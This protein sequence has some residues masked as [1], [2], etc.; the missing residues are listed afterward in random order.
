MSHIHSHLLTAL[1]MTRVLTGSRSACTVNCLVPMTALVA[2]FVLFAL[3][4][5]MIYL[6]LKCFL[7]CKHGRH[8]LNHLFFICSVG[9]LSCDVTA[10]ISCCSER[11]VILRNRAYFS[12]F[13]LIND[14]CFLLHQILLSPWQ[15]SG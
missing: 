5:L 14:W 9:A 15:Q 2:Y 3:F 4:L 10:Q 8:T 7:T 11:N 1:H 12:Y 6:F 13:W